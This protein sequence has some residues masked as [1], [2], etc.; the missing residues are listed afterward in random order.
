MPVWTIVAR[1]AV[2][3]RTVRALVRVSVALASTKLEETTPQDAIDEIN[4]LMKDQMLRGLGL[5]ELYA[6]AF[7]VRLLVDNYSYNAVLLHPKELKKVA[8][9]RRSFLGIP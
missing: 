2:R 6:V 4:K 9:P 1:C 5:K 7:Y 3:C 8:I